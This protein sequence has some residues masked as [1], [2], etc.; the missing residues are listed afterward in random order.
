MEVV[1]CS[2]WL[3]SS[4]FPYDFGN[5]QRR[6]T[7]LCVEGS[8]QLPS[9]RGAAHKL[10]NLVRWAEMKLGSAS[11]TCPA[12]AF[13][14]VF[15]GNQF[16]GWRTLKRLAR[17]EASVKHLHV[18][19]GAVGGPHRHLD[20]RGHARGQLDEGGELI[21]EANQ[22]AVGLEGRKVH[23]AA[24]APPI[25]GPGPRPGVLHDESA[26]GQHRGR[27]GVRALLVERRRCGICGTRGGVGGGGGRSGG[28]ASGNVGR[29]VGP[30]AGS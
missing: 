7:S 1:S 21:Q 3:I 16:G 24:H 14:V 13:F 22:K 12:A 29:S 23:P 20:V 19:F 8:K 2:K 30:N 9:R 26:Q 25:R 6:S 10:E 17:Q 11:S 4:H 27:D 15:A 5:D 18:R 28:R